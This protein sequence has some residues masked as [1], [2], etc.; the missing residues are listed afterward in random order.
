MVVVVVVVVVV[1]YNNLC[2]AAVQI[3][4]IQD[5][6]KIVI[7]SFITRKKKRKLK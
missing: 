7:Q 1:V 2:A 4:D 3:A 6:S 5:I